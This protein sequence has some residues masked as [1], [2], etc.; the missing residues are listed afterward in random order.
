MK[1]EMLINVLQPEECRIAIVENGVLEE[2]YVERTSQESY[3]GN[4]YKGRIVNIEPSIQAAFVDFGIGRNG[5]LHVS[6]VDPAYYRHLEPAKSTGDSEEGERGSRGRRGRRGDRTD[7]R[8]G[9]RIEDEGELTPTFDQAEPTAEVSS[10]PPPPPLSDLRPIDALTPETISPPPPRETQ[11]IWGAALEILG[12]QLADTPPSAEATPPSATA[13]KG[14]TTGEPT[15]GPTAAA[16]EA[17]TTESAPPLAAQAIPESVLPA[18]E[19][20]GRGRGRGG[21]SRR[22]RGRKE[23]SA[24]T[25]PAT[26]PEPQ[27]APPSNSDTT[28]PAVATETAGFGAGIWDDAAPV[29]ES[30]PSV[31]QTEAP[32]K[33]SPLAPAMEGEAAAE[34]PSEPDEIGDLE[35]REAAEEI[36]EQI[37]REAFSEGM[38]DVGEGVDGW[39]GDGEAA[40]ALEERDDVLEE[41]EDFDGDLAE[42]GEVTPSRFRPRGGRG[43]FRRGPRR[44][45]RPGYGRPKPLIQDI[46][47]RGQEV[48][49][50]VIKEGI[51][52][53]GPTL[54]TYISIAGRYLV[55]MPGLNRIG[56]SRKIIDEEA[57]SRLKEIL[58]A[59][60]PP[61]GI[62]FIIR[63]AGIDRNK[64][65][66]QNDLAYLLRLWQVMVKRIKKVKGPAEIYQESDMIT[67]TIRDVF[68]SDI[69]TIW[70]DEPNAF[71]HAQEFLQ[72]VM[73]RY[74]D[75][76]KQ[77][78]DTEPLFYKY[79]IEEEI[80][81]IQQKKIPLPMGGSIVIEQTE[82]LVA[83]DV[84]SGNFR[85]DGNNAEETAY[86]M[87]LLAAK[88]IARQ[89]RLRDLG[90]V[91]VNDFIDMREEKHKRGV[92]R[93][94]K[95]ALKRDRARTKILRTSQFGLIEMTRQR[96]RPSLKRSVYT[97][98]P[99]C[100]G[101]GLVKTVESMS[102]EVMR[103][104]QLAAHRESVY[105]LEIRVH[106]DVANY[107]L[108]RRRRE[109]AQLEE[110]GEMQVSILGIPGAAPET[111]N[112][113]CF[114]R[115][116]HEVKFPGPPEA[117]R[118]PERN[119]RERRM[120]R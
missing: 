53:K 23:E 59:L 108:N 18:I 26:V 94:L 10:E 101:T 73:P 119:N 39:N 74:A 66:L 21:R 111:L 79:R 46:F 116:G 62:G 103:L 13:E 99:H 64:A 29:H 14:D 85:A 105:R 52:T 3:V 51:G 19:E 33:D 110:T 83:I 45:G 8:R 22:G 120:L 2:L 32:A 118:L 50:Q 15:A 77:Y 81:K 92:E 27:A 107:L 113:T 6:D 9:G 24:P 57:R 44:G 104:L 95:E 28:P 30:A 102:I 31:S 84:N 37:A 43:G 70:V 93:A 114:D 65:E 61:K 12:L 4:I 112:I 56:V 42:T 97:D 20:P 35:Q 75:R 71:A 109:I 40:H 1:K 34:L 106:A 78:T 69:D 88:E 60:K 16:V 67:R 25:E 72:I 86:Q 55:L 17:P 87:N 91:I 11:S 90:G 89:L 41:E 115:N 49:V 36:A 47:K 117:P 58:T 54:S 82:A 48:I 68:T 63:T 7:R 38:D 80:A 100:N 76:I 5:F 96:I 98:C